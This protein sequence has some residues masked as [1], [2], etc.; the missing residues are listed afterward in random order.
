[1][2]SLLRKVRTLDLPIDIQ[3]QLFHTLV[4]PAI[5]MYGA[6]AWEIEMSSVSE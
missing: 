1:M 6:E 3:L 4:T 2:F 5:F